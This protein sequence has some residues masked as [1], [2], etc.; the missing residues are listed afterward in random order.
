MNRGNSKTTLFLMEL[1][2]VILVFSICS[3][4]SLRVF[5][6]AVSM[7]RQ[8]AALNGSVIAVETAAECFKETGSLEALTE[9]IGGKIKDEGLIINYDKNWSV[10]EKADAPFKTVCHTDGARA[11]ISAYDS[12]T[13]KEIFSVEA[14]YMGGGL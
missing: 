1:T 12:E 13:D 7:S 4:V 10:T 8:S 2:L 6:K 3:A 14:V 5:T 9:L 11:T